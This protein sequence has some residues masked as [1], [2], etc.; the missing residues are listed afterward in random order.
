MPISFI[1]PASPLEYDPEYDSDK[2][3]DLDNYMWYGNSASDDCSNQ[4]RY[5]NGEIK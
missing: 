3:H 4:E 1:I 2:R 5:N